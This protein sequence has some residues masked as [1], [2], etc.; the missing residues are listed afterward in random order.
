MTA[1][2]TTDNAEE[3]L[4]RADIREVAEATEK[5]IRDS[6]REDDA[7]T[8]LL[9]ESMK[10]SLFSGGKRIRAYL[11]LAF[12]RLFGG[13]D[14]SALPFAAALEM[15]HTFSL[16][17]DDLPCMDNDELRRGKP[18][19]HIV[20][21]EATALLA[22]DAI[23]IKAFEV[24]AGNKNV[25]ERA[26]LLA[27]TSLSRAAAENGMTG[28]QI[29]DIYGETHPLSLEKLKKLQ[30]LKTGEL[31]REGA[32]LGAY[33]A[34]LDDG[35]ERLCDALEYASDLGLA[36][37]IR[38]DILDVIGDERLLGKPIGSD[39]ESGKTTF[40]THMGLEKAEE[41]AA[42][43]TKGAKAAIS[44]YDG[45]EKLSALADMLLRR[46]S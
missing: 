32:R 16:I 28:G 3:A 27:V 37:Q 45:A 35:D 7:D 42:L 21:G 15:V 23:L 10:Y 11:V 18:T 2:K 13:S 29:M 4:L 31:I 46:D 38:D 20:Y 17:H 43:L 22:G 30:S 36:F 40:V 34:G 9:S 26:R 5:Y 41:Y 39:A 6:F 25:T 33:A 44:H 19:N 14:A 24:A 8:A 12:C 1:R